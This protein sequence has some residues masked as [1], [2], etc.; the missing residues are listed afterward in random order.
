VEIC[1]LCLASI[2]RRSR[3][4]LALADRSCSRARRSLPRFEVYIFTGK[5]QWASRSRSGRC[6]PSVRV[7]VGIKLLDQSGAIK[8]SL[9]N[10]GTLEND[11]HAV[12]PSP[13]L[14]GV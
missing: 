9:A 7:L 12:I 4:S 13:I 11:G 8:L 2:L 3:A 1:A 6:S 10:R 14:G 5:S